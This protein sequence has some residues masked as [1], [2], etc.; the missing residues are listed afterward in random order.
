MSD[1]DPEAER[2]RLREK[3]GETGEDD[4]TERM[5][6]LLLQ[7]ATM[8]NKHCET[9]GSPLF[10]YQGREFCPT[11]QV[12]VGEGEG[13][14][15]DGQ[16]VGS[17]DDEPGAQAGRAVGGEASDG[18]A[19]PNATASAGG[20][21]AATGESPGRGSAA[22]AEASD[23]RSETQPTPGGASTGTA[24]PTP[25]AGGSAIGAAAAQLAETVG[26]LARRARETDDPAQARAHLE[27]AREAAEALS[28]LQSRR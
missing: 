5:S 13:A 9:C 11:C 7:G 10:R 26:Q 21:A 22:G 12:A 2:E 27:A 8:L 14:R 4:P 23:A 28:A 3:Y 16:R 17:E 1:F 6:E 24:E 18:Q 15:D 25:A 20:D 19:R